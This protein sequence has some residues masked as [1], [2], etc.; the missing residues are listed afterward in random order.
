MADVQDIGQPNLI[1]TG[2]ILTHLLEDFENISK[3]VFD[4]LADVYA[5][6]TPRSGLTD[7]LTKLVD[8]LI[9]KDKE[10]KTATKQAQTQLDRQQQINQCR[11]EILRKD[12]EIL[13]LQTQLKEAEHILATALFQAK[14]KLE[15]T[16]QATKASVSSEELIKFAFRISSGNSVEAPEDWMPGDPRRP[17]PLDIEMRSGALGLLSHKGAVPPPLP[18]QGEQPPSDEK[19]AVKQEEK[20]EEAALPLNQVDRPDTSRGN[21]IWQGPPSEDMAHLATMPVA[22]MMSQTNGR[23][24]AEEVEFMSSSS[25]SS[26]SGDSN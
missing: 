10:I 14:K 24:N 1:S 20:Q 17:Y 13:Q 19:A 6:K 22:A 25:D 18:S 3:E 2:E 16:D 9:E 11:E 26:S 5:Q 21:G 8:N 15:A 7:P 4:N 23:L 12:Q